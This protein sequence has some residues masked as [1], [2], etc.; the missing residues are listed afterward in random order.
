MYTLKFTIAFII[1]NLSIKHS[2]NNYFHLFNISIFSIL[3]D[4]KETNSISIMIN[5][6]LD[7]KKL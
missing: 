6:R 7:F 4:K 3:N 5:K 2:W 1:S